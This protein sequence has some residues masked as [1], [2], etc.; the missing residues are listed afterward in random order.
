ML[1]GN[2]TNPAAPGLQ[3]PFGHSLTGDVVDVAA[4]HW[5]QK[6]RTSEISEWY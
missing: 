2:A 6:D 1:F 5:A 3:L 4:L